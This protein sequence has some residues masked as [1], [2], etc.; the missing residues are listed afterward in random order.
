MI[1][2]K[3]ELAYYLECDRIALGKKRKKPN[4]FGDEI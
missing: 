4:L 1:S 2:T 3:E